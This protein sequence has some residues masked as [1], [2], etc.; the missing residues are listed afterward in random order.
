M[1]KFHKRTLLYVG[2]I[3]FVALLIARFTDS[4]TIPVGK[5]A[6][7]ITGEAIIINYD[8][9]LETWDKAKAAWLKALETYPKDGSGTTKAYY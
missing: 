8:A 3:L 7:I 5:D 4:G 1:S 2:V 6:V 9:S